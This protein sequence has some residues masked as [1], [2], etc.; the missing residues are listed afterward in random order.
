MSAV[1]NQTNLNL[2]K[3]VDAQDSNP[4]GMVSILPLQFRDPSGIE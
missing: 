2:N 3:M 1:A 4:M